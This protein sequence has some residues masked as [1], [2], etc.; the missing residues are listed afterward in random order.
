MALRPLEDI[1]GPLVVPV[2]GKDYTLPAVSLSDGLKIHASRTNGA[3]LEADELYRILLGETFQQML[4][5]HVPGDV[6]DRVFLAAYT[7]FTSGRESAEEV[8][9]NG[10]PKAMRDAA[11][12]VLQILRDGASTTTPPAFGNGT[13]PPKAKATRSR[14]SKSSPT[15]P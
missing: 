12:E 4:T 11:K 13:T 5:D 14:G 2:R 9:E 8:W 15:S 7:D 10:V 6:I 1:L 3:A